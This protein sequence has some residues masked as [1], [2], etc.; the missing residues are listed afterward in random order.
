M[1]NI[2]GSV[3]LTLDGVMQGPGGPT[4]DVTGSFDE[5]G[6]VFKF[7]DEAVG[8]AIGALFAREYDLLL[9]RRTY[10][11][12]AA[13]WPYVEGEEAAMG[14]AF[15]RAHK[16]VLTRSEQPLAWANSHRLKGI[17][18]VAALK[19]GDGPDLI[20]QGSG[21]IYPGLLAAGLVD[22][23][24]LMTFPVTLGKGKRLF[25]DGTPATMLKMVDHKV[26]AKGTVIATYEPGGALP[27]FPPFGPQPSTS[28][29]EA[30][31][32]RRMAEG[33]W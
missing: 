10:D 7:W 33:S 18:D 32:Q 3:F 29:R 26:T 20:I 31:R 24:M 6:W 14:E 28:A 8:E 19:Q 9:G 22:R 27:A 12:F 25:C 23:L 16:Y 11:I 2:V 5:G 1:R 4:E 15:T 30:E 13:Y 21:T 17:D